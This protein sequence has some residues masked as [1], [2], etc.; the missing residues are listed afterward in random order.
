M[1]LPSS[2]PAKYRIFGY[3]N[4][5]RVTAILIIVSVNDL[6]QMLDTDWLIGEKGPFKNKS[7]HCYLCK[8]YKM[9]LNYMQGTMRKI[10]YEKMSP[11]EFLLD[12]VIFACSLLES[13]IKRRDHVTFIQSGARWPLFCGGEFT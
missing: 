11:L 6:R 5:V 9:T 1:A 7:R 3:K 10:C 4:S 12:F 8:Q 13:W 2:S